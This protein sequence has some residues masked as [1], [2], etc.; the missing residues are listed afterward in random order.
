MILE[1]ENTIR[2]F[3]NTDYFGYLFHVSYDGLMFDS[4]DENPDMI[5]VK[6]KFR[7][8]LESNN[9]K[10]YKG[11]QQAGRTDKDV[12]ASNNILY[13]NSKQDIKL[14]GLK[15][16]KTDGLTITKIEKT[17]PFLE[18]PS[19]IKSMHYVYK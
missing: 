7:E 17:M 1:N 15:N 9:I 6:S 3:E 19:L 14:S 10:F 5:S 2:K 12:S 11:I 18:L 16:F 13:I 8:L 4:F